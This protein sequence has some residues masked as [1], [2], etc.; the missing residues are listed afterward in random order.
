MTNTGKPKR[1]LLLIDVQ[2]EYVTGNL[3]IEYPPLATS[4]KNIETAI[5]TAQSHSIPIVVVQQMAPE[6][7]P[8]FAKGSHG[9]ELHPVVASLK[10]DLLVHKQ[11]PSALAGTQLAQW[12]KKEDIDTLTVTG[13]MTQNC[14]ESTIRQATHEGW[15]VEFLHDAAGTVSFRNSQGHLKAEDMHKAA[16][17]VLQSRFAAVM[18]TQEWTHCIQTG[19]APIRDS[20]YQSYKQAHA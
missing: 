8:I 5:K 6:T 12:L 18:T 10:P 4:L 14:N 17:V 11:L 16:C 13:Y 3:P 9:W 7:S 15:A 1:A 19:E 20:L 2:N